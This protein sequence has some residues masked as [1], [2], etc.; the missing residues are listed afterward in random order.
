MVILVILGVLPPGVLSPTTVLLLKKK[1]RKKYEDMIKE[2]SLTA[3]I[4]CF[5]SWMEAVPGTSCSCRQSSG[6]VHLLVQQQHPNHHPH[7]AFWH[8]VLES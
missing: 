2:M 3:H 5:G 1:K 8:R 4:T 7:A 6:L